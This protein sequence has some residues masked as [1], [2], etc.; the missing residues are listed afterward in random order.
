[1]NVLTLLSSPRSDGNTA[2][3]LG[4]VEDTLRRDKHTIERIGLADLH[5]AGCKACFAC[6]ES[7]DEP[8]CALTD[9]GR[10]VLE[11]MVA[12]DAILFATPLFMWSYAGQ[13]KPLLDRTLCLARD[14]MGQNHRSFVAEKPA[15]LLVTCGGPIERNADA[16]QL[17]FPRLAE[18]L[19]LDD[20]GVWVFPNCTEPSQLPNAHGQ[21]AR[22]LARALAA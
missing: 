22:E 20:R 14:Y 3:V 2:T 6:T 12:V 15:A 16:V 5:I 17:T 7:A 4:W 18:Y 21:R 1:M 8:G 10:Q 11:R 19:K 13:L 9:D